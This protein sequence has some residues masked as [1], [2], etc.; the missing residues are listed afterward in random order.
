[1]QERRAWRFVRRRDLGLLEP[2]CLRQQR[3]QMV[4]PPGSSRIE[5][6]GAAGGRHGLLKAMAPLQQPALVEVERG[7][8]GVAFERFA[9]RGIGLG[10]FS[11][12]HQ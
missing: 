11:R 3:R 5:L 8:A 7:I 4:P 12:V 1:L 9:Q 10:V 6:A 2:A